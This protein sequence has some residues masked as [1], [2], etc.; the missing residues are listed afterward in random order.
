[1]SEAAWRTS[2][3]ALS[4]GG[5]PTTIS[6]SSSDATASAARSLRSGQRW[7]VGS[8]G[9]EQEGDGGVLIRGGGARGKDGSVSLCALSAHLYSAMRSITARRLH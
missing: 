8:L 4:N 6:S 2:G 5:G 9:M 7:S 1:M 3:A